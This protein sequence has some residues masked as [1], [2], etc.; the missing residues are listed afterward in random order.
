MKNIKINSIIKIFLFIGLITNVSIIPSIAIYNPALEI[1]E[2]ICNEDIKTSSLDNSI[3]VKNELT[4]IKITAHET[5]TNGSIK[6]TGLHI[7]STLYGD[8]NLCR[9]YNVEALLIDIITNP[10]FFRLF[11]INQYGLSVYGE[12]KKVILNRKDFPKYT[13]GDHSIGIAIILIHLHRPITEIICALLHDY[14]HT[15]GSHLGDSLLRRL[16]QEEFNDKIINSIKK[17]INNS[18]EKKSAIQDMIFE[19]YFKKTGIIKTLSKYNIETN[20]ILLKNNPVIKQSAP[21]LCADNLEY[22]LT[23]CFLAKILNAK[24]VNKIINSLTI[25]NDSIWIFRHSARKHAI[26]L[27]K[28]SIKFD[29]INSAAPW[30]AIMN[31]YGAI[32]FEIALRSKIINVNEL[33]FAPNINDEEIWKKITSQKDNPE[34]ASLIE[35]V[36]NPST[37]LKK[38]SGKRTN[39]HQYK[40]VVLKPRVID[41]FVTSRNGNVLPL[42]ETHGTVRNM[43]KRHNVV[44][45]GVICKILN[46]DK[47]L[48]GERE[49]IIGN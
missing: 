32:L 30:S 1:E 47:Y 25:I 42:S 33:I 23:G 22:T 6:I 45:S 39:N 3:L 18:Q 19:W 15:K 27:S 2:T 13:R 21:E 44:E 14:T 28:A 7:H 17:Q 37:V 29:K 31:Y 26:M 10:Y 48:L 9:T 38:H 24:E 41:P 49:A 43:L 11:R 8:V 36:K 12:F 35:K 5:T 4:E 20:G 40:L 16:I 34:I 46:L